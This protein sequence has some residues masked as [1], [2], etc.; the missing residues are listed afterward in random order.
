MVLDKI[1]QPNDIKNLTKE[2]I[3]ALPAEIRT[4]LIDHLSKTGGHLASNLGTVELTIALHLLLDFPKDKLVW[5]VGHQAYTHKILTGRADE[6]DHLR[7]YGGL[8]G[9][10]KRA[11]SDCDSFD[12]GHSSTSLSAA[13]GYCMAR[14]LSGDDYKVAAVIGDG[15]LTGGLAYEAL[16]NASR[17]KK[18]NFLIILNDNEMSISKNV[19]GMSTNLERL[20]TSSKYVGLKNNVLN[21]LESWPNGEKIIRKI[22]STKNGIKSL[23]VPN[24]VFED[25]GIMYLGPVDGHNIKAMLETFKM[26]INI[27]GPVLVHVI[28]KKGNGYEPAERHPSRFHGTDIFE[29]ETGLPKRNPNPGYTDVF[30]TV[31]RKMGDRN[32]EVVAITAAMAEGAGLKRF[33][34]M[35]PDRFFDVGIAEEHAV[36]FAA[37]LALGG[38]TPV[39]AVYS[40]FLQR[41]YDQILED[42]C[43]QNLHVVFAIDR[44]G[45]VGAD[46]STHQGIF[47]VSF[48][49]SMPNMTVMAPKNKWELSDMMKYAVGEH[50]GPIAIRYPRGEAYCG[51]KEQRAPIELGKAEEIKSGSKVMLLALGSMVKKAEEVEA[52]LQEKGIDAGICNARFAKPLDK[53]YLD[54]IKNQYDMIVTMEENVVTGGFGEHVQAYLYDNGFKGKVLKIAVPD[55]FVRHGSVTL[56]FKE[57]KMDAE[58]IAE[59]VLKA[60]G[61]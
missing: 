13:L 17:L 10:P 1:K 14:D 3:E 30:S 55:E 42:V 37:G 31:M 6:F 52:L 9:F 39:F 15:A 20:R 43:L 4:F 26:A 19:G 58:S 11:E 21:S 34:N 2:E 16:N 33:R 32:P 47:D 61:N 38:R 25:L 50:K 46:G 8:S 22:R 57:L 5:D 60:L 36:T 48:L 44:A 56:L 28:T 12:T 41:A 53:A 49:T 18:S 27:D 54:G 35:F 29:I 51:L 45:L 23:M 7:Q 24:M 40:S 59:R